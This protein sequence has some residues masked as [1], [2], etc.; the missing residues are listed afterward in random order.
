MS[1]VVHENQPALTLSALRIDFRAVESAR[2]PAWTGSAWRGALGHALRRAVC[3]TCAP[4][5][6]GCLLL[7]RCPYPVLFDLARIA[8]PGAPNPYVLI[9]SAPPPGGY[10]GPGTGISLGLVLVGE[11]AAGKLPY[12]IHALEHA[13]NHGLTARRIR[14]ELEGVQAWSANGW[15]DLQRRRDGLQR[16]GPV[17]VDPPAVPEAL[18]VR[19]HSPLRVRHQGRLLRPEALDFRQFFRAVGR[20]IVALA[21]AHGGRVEE[22]R[23]PELVRAAGAVPVLRARLSWHDLP[24]YS[25]RQRAPMRMGGIVGS[26][27]LRGGGLEPFWPWLWLGQWVH[28]GRATTMGLGMYRIEARGLPPLPAW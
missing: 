5:C 8:G 24:R 27:E 22:A 6:A 17:V 1:P 25:S 19:L 16:P 12:L 13:G 3:V 15:V 21:R 9:P 4:S 10:L 7:E 14:L 26:F 11:R 20:R 2:L 28:A 23:Y 18:T